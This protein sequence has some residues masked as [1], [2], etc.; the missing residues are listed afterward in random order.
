MVRFATSPVVHMYA[1]KF[2]RRSS[3]RLAVSG[4]LLALLFMWGNAA[5]ALDL[6]KG[7]LPFEYSFAPGGKLDPADELVIEGNVTGS[8]TISVVFRVDDGLSK[9]WASR[10][11]RE[12]MF[13]PGFFRWRIKL[14]DTKTRAGRP[15]NLNDL[16]R[17]VVG[18]LDG[19]ANMVVS[20]ATLGPPLPSSFPSPTDLPTGRVTVRYEPRSPVTF[21]DTDVLT[22]EGVVESKEPAAFLI[23]IDDTQ[24]TNYASR[25]NLERGLAPGPFRFNIQ[26]RGLK[27][28]SGRILDH[29]SVTR[30]ILALVDGSNSVRITQFRV[31]AAEPLPNGAKA[32]TLAAPD[33]PVMPGFERIAPGDRRL[34]GNVIP[35]RRVAP[36]PAVATGLRGIDFVRL[37]WPGGR[38][39]VSLFTE[40]P[41]EWEFLPN[42]LRRTIRVNG[43]VAL[44]RNMT[45][46]QW[47][48][49][50]YL[51][52]ADVEHGQSD[53]AWT[54]YGRHRGDVVSVEVDTT[55]IGL[56]I[57]LNGQNADARY[58]STIVVE[59]AGQT[60]AI[61]SV[62]RARAEWYR[63]NLQ[64]G[65]RADPAAPV[66][67]RASLDGRS[68]MPTLRATA[69]AGV[70]AWLS[71]AVT[72][73]E[74]LE[75]PRISLE[76]PALG[77]RE[78]SARVWVG[79]RRLEREDVLL[80]RDNRLV[81][82]LSQ[83]P[84]GPDSA[85]N[86]EIWVHV[87]EHTGPGLYRG[88]L[89]FAVPGAQH[90][91]PIEIEVLGTKMPPLAKPVGFY[92]FRPAHYPWFQELAPRVRQQTACDL[93]T[94]AF[95][96]V[97]AGTAPSGEGI[98][99]GKL[100][101]FLDDMKLA[102]AHGVAPGWLLYNISL[103]EGASIEDRAKAIGAASALM[104]TNGLGEP[105]WS[106]A[107]EP[108]NAEQHG[109]VSVKEWVAALRKHAPLAKL[110]A[111]LNS[112]SD[113]A[114]VPMFDVSIINSGFG[115]DK[116]IIDGL[117]AQG[118][119]VW[120]YNSEN[121]R[122][123][124]GLW[125]WQTRAERYV[126]WHARSPHADPFDP[127][128]GR[129]S[130]YQ[131]FYPT[132]E[133]CPRLPAVHRDLLR[134]ANG[135]VDQRWLS[136]LEQQKGREADQIKTEIARRVRGNWVEARKLSTAALDG[137]RALITDY[138]RRS[139]AA[140][141]KSGAQ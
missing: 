101:G 81:S 108:S 23:R 86:Y 12:Q 92:H 36:D 116:H 24:S 105:L 76:P 96:G 60:A 57:E 50:R 74:K 126:Q 25:V 122:V 117:A 103:D 118:R 58:L 2:R 104:I 35:V 113:A 3:V 98:A 19:T 83:L 5:H 130:D 47:I 107:D 94:L 41:G 1:P 133:P 48:A 7:P 71:L 49:E 87:P 51:R 52:L 62:Q 128:D 30:I 16:K 8:G 139:E 22:V 17:V 54:A 44:T 84:L 65:E 18:R 89:E 37:P 138:A 10:F 77:S 141:R 91:V 95:F 31:S 38:V 78:L 66:Y 110:A 72:A 69:A 11:N 59:P 75:S 33:A 9:D 114:T 80:L 111:Q 119:R 29:A 112:K 88:S 99:V 90:R 93:Q 63:S 40:D 56:V 14:A 32:Y 129:E 137:I 123:S 115:L 82:N 136:W 120:L 140:G 121:L 67:V 28:P 73:P 127:T 79:Q 6:G 134:L 124:A 85:R 64:K 70:G 61:E 46:S 20:R 97:V 132:L 100:N 53:D 55:G 106:A 34:A 42:P 125:L 13:S 43:K 135:A 26:P 102:K 21:G 4:L 15:L 131:M 39:R 68:A 27:T 109:G 45:P